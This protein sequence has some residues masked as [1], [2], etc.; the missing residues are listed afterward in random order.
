MFLSSLLC[1]LFAL[2]SGTWGWELLSASRQLDIR[3]CTI[4]SHLAFQFG[5]FPLAPMRLSLDRLVQAVP[6]L[7]CL[8]SK[9]PGHEAVLVQKQQPYHGTCVWARP[10]CP[11]AKLLLVWAQHR[12]NM[13]T[14]FLSVWLWQPGETMGIADVWMFAPDWSSALVSSY[15]QR[16]RFWRNLGRLTVIFGLVVSNVNVSQAAMCRRWLWKSSDVGGN[17]L[18]KPTHEPVMWAP[19]SEGRGMEGRVSQW[20]TWVSV[21]VNGGLE[22]KDHCKQEVILIIKGS[23]SL[24]KIKQQ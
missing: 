20:V 24:H 22:E 6:G 3:D 11:S 7:V 13:T 8:L 17:M 21:D 16:V 12:A 1:S 10:L 18:S 4:K 19:L 23:L 2:D 15:Y 14:W 9:L 5:F